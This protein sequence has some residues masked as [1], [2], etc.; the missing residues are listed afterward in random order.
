M[1]IDNFTKS[2]QVSQFVRKTYYYLTALH[3]PAPPTAQQFLKMGILRIPQA[4]LN[5]VHLLILFFEVEV[6][7]VVPI[8]EIELF[9]GVNLVKDIT[10]DEL[11]LHSKL[12]SIDFRIFNSQFV[13]VRSYN[14]SHALTR[15]HCLNENI[16]S[17]CSNL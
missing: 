15:K 12:L 5:F 14:T 11:G 17:T 6:E 8:D 3:H 4:N 7:G 2:A 13:D 9:G 1:Q 10:D 16:S